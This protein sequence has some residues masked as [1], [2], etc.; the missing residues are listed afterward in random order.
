MANPTEQESGALD[1]A[2]LALVVVI[3]IAAIFGYY[4]AGDASTLLRVV[5]LLVAVAVAVAIGYTTHKGRQL[6]GFLGNS[7]T[8]VRKMVWPTRIETT[9]TTLIVIAITI[10]VALMLWLMDSLFGWIIGR[11]VL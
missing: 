2:K 3:L 11:F 5:G 4:W 1:T 9:Q 8:E 10:L 6:A 7:R